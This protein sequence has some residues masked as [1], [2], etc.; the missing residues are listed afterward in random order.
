MGFV[1]GKAAAEDGA[2]RINQGK[3]AP[4]GPQIDA[5]KA[6]RF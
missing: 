1:F 6:F 3:F 4:A 5:K 2:L